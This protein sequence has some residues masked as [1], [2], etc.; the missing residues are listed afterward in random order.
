MGQCEPLFGR[1]GRPVENV[2]SAHDL[3]AVADD[4]PTCQDALEPTRVL[5]K[6]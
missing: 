5:P 1:Q 3:A 4:V 6:I 2:E